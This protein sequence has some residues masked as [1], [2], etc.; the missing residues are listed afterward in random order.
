MFYAKNYD[1]ASRGKYENDPVMLEANNSKE[2]GK[3]VELEEEM[4]TPKAAHTNPKKR[5]S[6]LKK[7]ERPLQFCSSVE[8]SRTNE[9]D[10][11]I[12]RQR[13]KNKSNVNGLDAKHEISLMMKK[14][15]I[16]YLVI[17]STFPFI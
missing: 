6:Y 16:L 5:K 3:E 2:K 14:K 8:T 13:I 12:K 15:T 1:S 7:S 10:N 4:W 9:V 11:N 17:L